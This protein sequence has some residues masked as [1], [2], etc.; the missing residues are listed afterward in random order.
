MPKFK[1]NNHRHSN[2]KKC[3]SLLA[4]LFDASKMWRST[5]QETT[6]DNTKEPYLIIMSDTHLSS[7]DGRWPETTAHFKSFLESMRADQPE[8]VFINGDILDNIALENGNPTC[9]DIHNW[10]K[11]LHAYMSA[12]ADFQDIDFLGSLGPNHDFIGDITMAYAAERLC[13]ARGSFSFGGFEFVWISCKFHSFSNDPVSREECFD[14]DDLVWLDNELDCKDK[15]ILLFHVPLT[16]EDTINRGAWSD[17]RSIIIPKEDKIYD[18]IDRHLNSIKMIFN[19]HIHGLLESDY[20]GIPLKIATF[21][22]QGHYCRVSV[23]DGELNVTV[24]TYPSNYS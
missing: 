3:R 24:H 19:G 1:A 10:K 14:I 7:Q 22:N 13:S 12:T 23:H 2:T 6:K 9:R 17:N 15:A 4:R 5:R 16:T 20:K 8:R 11:D 18:V 21:Y